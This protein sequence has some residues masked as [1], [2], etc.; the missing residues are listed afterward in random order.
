MSQEVI[1]TYASTT[2]TSGKTFNR[3][4]ELQKLIQKESALKK[5]CK[6]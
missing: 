5:L 2:K 4:C 6:Y 1:E 3:L